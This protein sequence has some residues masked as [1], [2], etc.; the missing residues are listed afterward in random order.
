[1]NKEI[2]KEYSNYIMEQTVNLLN[3]DS[4]SGYGKNVM[5][6]LQKELNGMG[7]ST[8]KTRKGGVVATIKGKHDDD[9]I[10]FEA[11][12]DTLGGMV[13]EIKSTGRLKITN[14]GGMLANNAEAE[15]VRI[16]TRGGRF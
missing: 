8:I 2:Y 3:I 13:R 6:Y 4:P 7:V 10:L 1:M 9:A 16:I 5:E 15:N 11:H 14:I 12:C